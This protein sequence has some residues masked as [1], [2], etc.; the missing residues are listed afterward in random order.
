MYISSTLLLFLAGSILGAKNLMYNFL[1][2]FIAKLKLAPV[3]TSSIDGICS[4]ADIPAT[5]PRRKSKNPC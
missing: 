2:Y 1:F 5:F 4:H 3:A